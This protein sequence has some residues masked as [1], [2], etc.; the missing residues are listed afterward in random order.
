[1][2]LSNLLLSDQSRNKLL[3]FPQH[4]AIIGVT[5][6]ANTKVDAK[7][8]VKVFDSADA[9]KAAYRA[10]TLKLDDVIEVRSTKKADEE[11]DVTR[12]AP[13]GLVFYRPEDVTGVED[14]A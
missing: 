3:A 9:V 11:P 12:E 10:G 4:E 1:M 14:D 8:P 7:K 13:V 2:T 6:A 5:H